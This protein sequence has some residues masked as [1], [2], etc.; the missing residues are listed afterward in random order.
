MKSIVSIVLVIMLSSC[1]MHE[2]RDNDPLLGLE[3]KKADVRK[4]C[5]DAQGRI[6]VQAPD[7]SGKSELFVAMI[8]QQESFEKM[9]A[10]ATGK[11]LDP[12]SADQ[13]TN[14]YDVM[15]TDIKE[16]NSS[17]R[18]IGGGVVSAVEFLGGIWGATKIVDSI[19]Q[20]GGVHNFNSGSIDNSTRRDVITSGP[21]STGA[22]SATGETH[23]VSKPVSTITYAPPTN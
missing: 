18:Q 4:S 2:F 15:N 17:L 5:Y 23:V 21:G 6:K 9:M 11:S 14:L 7:Y 22:I 16:R 1:G 13:G 19:G 20:N 8:K 3:S 12:C 10:L